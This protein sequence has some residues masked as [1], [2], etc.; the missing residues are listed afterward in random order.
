MAHAPTLVAYASL[1][2]ATRGIAELIAEVLDERGHP[3]QA[4]AAAS[5]TDATVYGSF[6]I[7]SAVFAGRWRREARGFVQRHGELLRQLPV[8]L[9]SSGP[10]G[11]NLL[12]KQGRSLAETS[13]PLDLRTLMALSGAREHAVFF[14][15]LDP[16]VL[17]RMGRL[18]RSIPAV[19]EVMPEG[20]FRDWAAIRQF[21]LRIADQLDIAVSHDDGRG[22]GDATGTSTLPS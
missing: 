3:A 9:F 1:Y 11:D 22:R 6:V 4:R 5:V 18:V 10:L 14:G 21:A 20:D 13:A 15:A 16:A 19:R 17:R 2:G 7:G 12:D 8:W